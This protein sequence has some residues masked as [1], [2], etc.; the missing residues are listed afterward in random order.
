MARTYTTVNDVVAHLL[1]V[2]PGLA[3]LGEERL[4]DIVRATRVS[5]YEEIDEAEFDAIADAAMAAMTDEPMVEC[6]YCGRDVPGAEDDSVP[7]VDDDAAWAE[8]A[9]HHAADCEWALTRAHRI[10]LAR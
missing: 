4:A 7:A 6:A 5:R 9:A 8:I 1:T 3:E 2:E 10:E